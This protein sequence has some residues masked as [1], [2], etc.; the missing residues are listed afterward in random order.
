MGR[1]Q[2]HVAYQTRSKLL[3][4]RIHGKALSAG[5]PG[6]GWSGSQSV[7][8]RRRQAVTPGDRGYPDSAY[9]SMLLV[10]STGTVW[11]GARGG[12]LVASPRRGFCSRTR[13]SWRNGGASDSNPPDTIPEGHHPKVGGSIP[14]E[15]KGIL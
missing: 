11:V 13:A 6:G 4:R 10:V 1:E 12:V 5:A 8:H 3:G 2:H 7:H 14:S 15:V 9:L